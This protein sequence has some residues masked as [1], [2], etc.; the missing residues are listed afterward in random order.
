M[1]EYKKHNQINEKIK[2][3]RAKDEK[4]PGETIFK[5]DDER[6]NK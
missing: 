3:K 4:Q 5:E 1:K 2:E 6:N